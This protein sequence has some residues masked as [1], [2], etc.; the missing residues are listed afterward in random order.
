MDIPDLISEGFNNGSVSLLRGVNSF[1][2]CSLIGDVKISFKFSLWLRLFLLVDLS[3][4]ECIGTC[5]K[6]LFVTFIL[7]HESP[8]LNFP[9]S[10][11]S[12]CILVLSPE[13]PLE[14]K[15][16]I[17]SIGLLKLEF[18]DILWFGKY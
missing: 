4:N 10:F 1:G 7:L 8:L 17:S 14:I 2:F 9:L 15:L 12:S 13:S 16:L 11:S 5:S 6:G 3:C 18:V